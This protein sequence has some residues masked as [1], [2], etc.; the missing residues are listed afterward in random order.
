MVD[1]T[2]YAICVLRNDELGIRGQIRFTQ[3][4]ETVT[5]QIDMSGLTK[6]KHGFHIHEFGKGIFNLRKP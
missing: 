1:N 4:G 5:I 6:G 3:V 2:T